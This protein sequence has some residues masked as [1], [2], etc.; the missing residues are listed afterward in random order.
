[1]MFRMKKMSLWLV[2]AGL[3]WLPLG[4]CAETSG[5][6]S[7]DPNPAGKKL[8]ETISLVTG[9]IWIGEFATRGFSPS[10]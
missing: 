2:V 9:V 1:M 7:A 3:L 10:S 4:A 5:G 8:C 6:K